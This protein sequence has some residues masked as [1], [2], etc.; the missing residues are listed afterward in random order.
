[1]ERDTAPARAAFSAAGIA[2]TLLMGAWCGP[3][4]GSSGIDIACGSSDRPLHDPT[5][6]A[7][8]ALAAHTESTLAEILDDETVQLPTLAEA[9]TD[10]R[11]ESTEEAEDAE[12]ETTL[13]TETPAIITR[14]PGVSDSVLPSFRRQMYRTDI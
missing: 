13:G 9:V 4:L 12:T 1:M 3:A 8:A 10:T 5:I 7:S 6:A 2:V 11:I 14:L